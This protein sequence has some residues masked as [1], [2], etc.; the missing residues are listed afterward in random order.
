MT[1]V[2]ER[3]RHAPQQLYPS[4]QSSQPAL[5]MEELPCHALEH[6]AW[7]LQ[8]EAKVVKGMTSALQI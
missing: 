5:K 2:L 8:E 3:C 7:D 6:V 1:L 4:I